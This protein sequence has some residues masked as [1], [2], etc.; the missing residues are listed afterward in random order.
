MKLSVI[1]DPEPEEWAF[2]GDP[3]FWRYLRKRL[4]RVN[5]PVDPQRLEGFIRSEHYRLTGTRLRPGSIG[6][7]E[8]FAHGGMTSGGISGEFWVKYAIPLLKERLAKA[9]SQGF[10][11]LK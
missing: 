3:Y 1:F 9:N 7:A 4:S 8:E 10:E 5:L 11:V 2:R 6:I